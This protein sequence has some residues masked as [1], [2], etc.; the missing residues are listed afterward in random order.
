MLCCILIICLSMSTKY[1]TW[2]WLTSCHLSY[3]MLSLDHTGASVLVT[4]FSVYQSTWHSSRNLIQ[5]S[6]LSM[7]WLAS[8]DKVT[9]CTMYGVT[10][11]VP[12][13]RS[14]GVSYRLLEV[15]WT[16]IGKLKKTLAL[17][18]IKMLTIQM[19]YAM[20]CL[21]EWLCSPNYVFLLFDS[22]NEKG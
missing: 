10:N 12:L 8:W 20:P 22:L 11:I 13:K 17:S 3:L 6:L 19:S 2:L 21:S 14:T 15:S 7:S 16:A 4:I 5:M 18:Q 9:I 1:K